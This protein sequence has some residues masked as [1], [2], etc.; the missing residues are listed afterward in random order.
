MSPTRPPLFVIDNATPEPT[1]AVSSDVSQLPTPFEFADGSPQP[2]SGGTGT[3][4]TAGSIA[5]R[6]SSIGGG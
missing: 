2:S 4:T 6:A 3:A 1:I 5:A